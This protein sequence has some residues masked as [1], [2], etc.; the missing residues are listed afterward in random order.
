[1]WTSITSAQPYSAANAVAITNIGDEPISVTVRRP[2]SGTDV[3]VTFYADGA[4]V[5]T[6]TTSASDPIAKS[7]FSAPGAVA[8]NYSTNRAFDAPGATIFA[9]TELSSPITT[10]TG[11]MLFGGAAI[12]SPGKQF[13]QLDTLPR[14][15]SF[16]DSTADISY[17]DRANFEDLARPFAGGVEAYSFAGQ[18]FGLMV[19]RPIEVVGCGGIQGQTLQQMIDRSGLSLSAQRKS[20]EDMIAL[21]PNFIVMHAGSVN[22]YS[23]LTAASTDADI[24]ALYQ[25]HKQLVEMATDAGIVVIDSGTVGF[26]GNGSVPAADLAKIRYAIVLSNGW[27]KRDSAANPYWCYVETEGVTHVAGAFI[28]GW[29][30]DGTHT[31]WLGGWHLANAEAA[32]Y[33][34]LYSVQHDHLAP[35]VYDATADFL[36]GAGGR[37]PNH[38]PAPNTGLTVVSNTS[39]SRCWDVGINVADPASNGIAIWHLGTSANSPYYGL[40]AGDNANLHLK[41][42]VLDAAGNV[43]QNQPIRYTIRLRMTSPTNADQMYFDLGA[44][45]CPTDADFAIPFAVPIDGSS[46][47]DQSQ[48][49]YTLFDLPANAATLRVFPEKIRLREQ[50]LPVA[51]IEHGAAKRKRVP[52]YAALKAL[53]IAKPGQEIE[54][55][56]F[57]GAVFT[58]GQFGGWIPPELTTR[59]FGALGMGS[60]LTL[61]SRFPTLEIA[62]MFFPDSTSLAETLDTAALK[63]HIMFVR[64]MIEELFAST[65]DDITPLGIAVDLGPGRYRINAQLPAFSRLHIRGASD[66]SMGHQET[67]LECALLPTDTSIFYDAQITGQ[68]ARAYT[69]FAL[70][71]VS[72]SGR[73][74]ITTTVFD[75]TPAQW[76]QIYFSRIEGCKFSNLDQLK[77]ATFT[78]SRMARNNLINMPKGCL[79]FGGSDNWITDN[80]MQANRNGTVNPTAGGWVME[81]YGLSSSRVDRNY[82]T[83]DTAGPSGRPH[84]ML[85][86]GCRELYL[87]DNWCDLSDGYA[88]RMRGCR[89]SEIRGGRCCKTGVVAAS[90]AI[91]LAGCSYVD[92]VDVSFSDS[93]YGTVLM[94]VDSGA[95]PNTHCNV[96]RPKAI[97]HTISVS[98][99]DGSAPDAATYL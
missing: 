85:L 81:M 65:E 1:M 38:L 73:P 76:T 64:G 56:E 49:Y 25:Q 23:G 24:L 63:K 9:A 4:P 2:A 58:R 61:A 71:N 90:Y 20:M 67:S 28:P 96:V 10:P 57:A 42:Q 94:A 97:S 86:D 51:Q 6:M 43:L 59:N 26:D 3:I 82:F 37:P 8:L 93:G 33:D 11:D 50:R 54:V 30:D 75:D 27:I 48:L 70:E 79:K 95:V 72:V 52:T 5:H 83:G 12:S 21:G 41:F 77:L 46:F 7:K 32:I 18:S 69:G 55:D 36:A 29:S 89:S 34:A 88:I 44:G 53:T 99:T 80:F 47:G 39:T 13:R 31:N 68:T 74:D 92:I 62:Q 84:I 60:A 14:V 40:K 98:R 45:N 78:G 35:P 17:W 16:G 91:E 66:C 22:S 15:V 19:H 87:T